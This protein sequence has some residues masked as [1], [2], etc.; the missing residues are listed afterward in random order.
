V[1]ALVPLL[2]ILALTGLTAE[3]IPAAA[4][5]G[6][7]ERWEAAVAVLISV[8]QKQRLNPVSD[9]HFAAAL[10]SAREARTGELP[11]D[12]AS[13]QPFIDAVDTAAILYQKAETESRMES[14]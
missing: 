10:E 13:A 6:L 3:E 8:E 14:V 5:H 2:G 1:V 12:G 7:R 4:R 9:S 11:R